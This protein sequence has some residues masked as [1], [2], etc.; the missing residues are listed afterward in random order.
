MLESALEEFVGT[1]LVV[2]HDRYFLDQVTGRIWGL[3]QGRLTDLAG[4]YSQSRGLA[5]S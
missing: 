1:A 2:S 5:R 3:E 4:N